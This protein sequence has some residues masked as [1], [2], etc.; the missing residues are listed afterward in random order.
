VESTNGVESVVGRDGFD[1][2][3]EFKKYIRK[4]SSAI[5]RNGVGINNRGAEDDGVA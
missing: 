5:E 3:R 1:I 4:E 2:Q